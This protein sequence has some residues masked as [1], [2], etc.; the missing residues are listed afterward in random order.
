VLDTHCNYIHTVLGAKFAEYILLNLD[1]SFTQSVHCTYNI[2]THDSTVMQQVSHTDFLSLLKAMPAL[3]VF[4][5]S[6]SIVCFGLAVASGRA[7]V[8]ADFRAPPY[9]CIV[10]SKV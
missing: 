1:I 2:S 5:G 10:N 6:K 8:V 9:T 7:L 4:L 3:R